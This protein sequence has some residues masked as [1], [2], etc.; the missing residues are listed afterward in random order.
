MRVS[1]PP[2]EL[3]DP[4][5]QTSDRRTPRDEPITIGINLLCHA[6]ELLFG[7]GVAQALE[8]SPIT[9]WLMRPWPLTIKLNCTSIIFSDHPKGKFENI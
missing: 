3:P 5:H 9:A 7:H 6:V 4:D 8:I 1:V 2:H